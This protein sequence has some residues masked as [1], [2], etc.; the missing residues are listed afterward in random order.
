MEAVLV[1][2]GG[3]SRHAEAVI[4][5][6]LAGAV[7]MA[8]H[9]VEDAPPMPIVVHAELEKMTQ[10]TSALRDAKGECMAD[11]GTGGPRPVGISGFGVPLRSA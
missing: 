3:A 8:Q 4:G 2:G 1:L 5:E 6:H 11:A 9:A 7:D 10:K